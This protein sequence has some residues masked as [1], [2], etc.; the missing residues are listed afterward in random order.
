[1]KSTSEKSDDGQKFVLDVKL[2]KWEKKSISQTEF[3]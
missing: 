1:M 2:N 3:V